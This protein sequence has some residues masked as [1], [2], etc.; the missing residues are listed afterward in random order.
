MHCTWVFYGM[1]IDVTTTVEDHPPPCSGPPTGPTPQQSLQSSHLECPP[2][3]IKIDF[4]RLGQKY[5]RVNALIAFRF[6][7]VILISIL[8]DR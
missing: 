5:K 6:V 2:L 3:R 8:L 1:S 7:L 4:G